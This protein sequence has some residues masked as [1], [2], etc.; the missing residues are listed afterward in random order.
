MPNVRTFLRDFGQRI[1]RV[2]GSAE[3]IADD[4]KELCGLLR[5]IVELLLREMQRE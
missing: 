2:G 3:L 5:K 4:G 1:P